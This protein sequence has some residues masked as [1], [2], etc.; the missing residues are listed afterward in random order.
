MNKN[1]RWRYAQARKNFNKGKPESSFD[2]PDSS[3]KTRKLTLTIGQQ[4][5][6]TKGKVKVAMS[7][8][9]SPTGPTITEQCE[10]FY[11]KQRIGKKS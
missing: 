11:G 7:G 3:T 1:S 8:I 10:W 6:L 2:I 4:T 5:K 9:K